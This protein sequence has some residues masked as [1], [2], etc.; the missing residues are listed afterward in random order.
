M[1]AE[2]IL[3]YEQYVRFGE[4]ADRAAFLRQP[5][6]LLWQRITSGELPPPQE[7]L[8]VLGPAVEGKHLLVSSLDDTE[9]AALAAAG[10]NGRLRPVEDDALAVITQNA[11]GNKI[12]WFL[13]RE[14]DYRVD[15]N[16][17]TGS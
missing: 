9:D 10:L 12:E 7:I 11:S 5:T 14:V 13:E 8:K 15:M 2:R 6:A 16:D 17:N 1:N 4:G 3:L